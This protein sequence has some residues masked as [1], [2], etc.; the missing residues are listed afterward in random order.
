MHVRVCAR[1]GQAA[2]HMTGTCRD[3]FGPRNRLALLE[4]PDAAAL[5]CLALMPQS[6]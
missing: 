3:P 4:V 6:R 5:L 1:L 2:A